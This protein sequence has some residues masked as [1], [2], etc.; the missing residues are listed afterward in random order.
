MSE[1]INGDMEPNAPRFQIAG[2]NRELPPNGLNVEQIRDLNAPYSVAGVELAHL[3]ECKA[4]PLDSDE[5]KIALLKGANEYLRRQNDALKNFALKDFEFGI[6][7]FSKTAEACFERDRLL[8]QLE[9][10]VQELLD[11]QNI[12]NEKILY[13]HYDSSAELYIVS[14]DENPVPDGWKPPA[15]LIPLLV[16]AGFY[17]FWV[18][19]YDGKHE[20]C[21]RRGE[22][23]ACKD[24]KDWGGWKTGPRNPTSKPNPRDER[25]RELE[26]ENEMLRADCATLKN[27]N[28]K[29]ASQSSATR[30]KLKKRW[31]EAV[32]AQRGLAT[33]TAENAR[34]KTELEQYH[35]SLHNNA[36][37]ENALREA[38]AGLAD[39]WREKA[40][41]E[42]LGRPANHAIDQIADRL[43]AI[44]KGAGE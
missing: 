32:L 12:W 28:Q 31:M 34:L 42:W 3:G 7:P 29:I 11:P 10:D 18:N 13:D 15:E 16:S 14:T 26:E 4:V 24:S 5:G 27:L 41:I 38:V 2:G 20:D 30:E 17:G 40:W 9:D 33:V 1:I 19:I 25:I 36:I 37:R 35:M 23:H 6:L 8:C 44:L 21:Y 39:E 43:D 22:W